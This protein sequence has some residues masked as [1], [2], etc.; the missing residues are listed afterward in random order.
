MDL[1]LKNITFIIVCFRSE[2]VI[3]NCLD[4]LP[5]NSKKIIIDNSKDIN[6][7]NDLELKYDN[8][9]V[10]LNENLG[11]GTSNNIGIKKS[12][13]QFV[14]IL[15]PDVSFIN[16]TFSKIAEEAKKIEDFT[17]ISPC[18]SNKDFPNFT[19]QKIISENISEVD[20]VDG[21]SMIL[22]KEKFNNNFFDENFFLYLE[23][24]DLCLRVKKRNEKIYVVKNS[25]INHLGASSSSNLENEIEYLRNW[26][27]MWSKFYFNKKHFGYIN[28]TIKIFTNL[29]S[30]NIKYFYYLITFNKHRRKTYQMRISGLLNSMIGNKSF[31]RLK[32]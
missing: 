19:N 20:S 10:I 12:N 3:Y 15:N 1:N 11:M 14:Y 6:L 28:A 24:D 7:K 8:I 31:Y 26:H 5:K 4:S 29:I 30:A 32:N 25:Y 23:N 17:I 9:E 21:F 13:T 18:H 27:W 22:N 2:K 16:N